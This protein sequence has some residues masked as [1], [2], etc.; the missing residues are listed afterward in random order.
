[1]SDVDIV[2]GVRGEISQSN[3]IT[4]RLDEIADRGDRATGATKRLEQ[5]FRGLNNAGSVLR[6]TLAAVGVGLA[7]KETITASMRLEQLNN[8]MLAAT[9]SSMDA[10]RSMAFVRQESERLGLVLTDTADG[11]SGFAASALRAGL[12]FGQTKQIFSDVATA[13][14]SLQLPGERVQLVF[15]AL[16]QMAAK[17]TV[18]MEELK[19]QLGE[20]LPGAFEIA[21]KSMGKTNA[22]FMEMVSNGEVLASEFLPKFAATLKDELG[23]SAVQAADSLQAATNRL[24]NAFFDLGTEFAKSGVADTY[25]ASINGVATVIKDP[26][27]L[28]A[29]RDVGA[30]MHDIAVQ[31]VEDIKLLDKFFSISKS[32]ELANLNDRI[33]KI[34]DDPDGYFNTGYERMVNDAELKSLEKKRDRIIEVQKAEE[35]LRNNQKNFEA[36]MEKVRE[37]NDKKRDEAAKKGEA[38]HVKTKS[39]LSTEKKLHNEITSAIKGSM[40][41]QEKL[42]A[43]IS[44]L[45]RLKGFAKTREEV[46]AL[47]KGIQN[48]QKEL[49]ELKLK[50]ELDS[51]LAKAFKSLADEIDDG[52]KDAFKSAFTESDGGFKKLIQGWKAT[53]KSFLADIAY[54]ALARP[55]VVSVLGMGGSAAGLSNGAVSSI[56]GGNGSSILGSLFSGSGGGG[57]SLSSIGSGISNINTLLNGGSSFINGIGSSLGFYNAVPSAAGV[58]G[59]VAPGAFGTTTLSGALAGGGLGIAAAQLL[60]LGNKNPYIATGAGIAGGAAAAGIAAALGAPL[61]PLGIGI[62]AFAGTALSGLFGGGTP[63]QTL[64]IGLTQNAAG[65]LSLNAV[66]NKNGSNEDATKFGNQIVEALNAL[67]AAVGGKFIASPSIE[68]NVGKKDPGTFIGGKRVSGT[69]G[70]LNA[71][72]RGYINNPSLFTGGNAQLT[73]ILKKS[74]GMGST[75]DQALQ[76][77]TLAKQIFGVTTDTTDQLATAM[78]ELNKQFDTMKTRASALGLPMDKVNQL[79]DDQKKALEGSIKALQAGFS[80]LEEMTQTFKAFLDAQALGSSSSLSPMEKLALVQSN[81]DSLLTKAQGGDASVTKDL[82]AAAATVLDVGRSIFASSKSFADL[83]AVIRTDIKEIAHQVGVPGYAVGTDYARSG[84]A[85]VG[86]QGPELVNFRGGESVYTASQ[87]ASMVGASSKQLQQMIALLQMLV[88]VNQDQAAGIQKVANTQRQA[89]SLAKVTK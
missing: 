80:S 35:I 26:E 24:Q 3:A 84:L 82:L 87:S 18:Q 16:E 1:M 75:A 54:Q 5:Q 48:T 89:N 31:M 60:G 13:A 64:G 52:F 72:I 20:S 62:G 33:A 46:D 7:F 88:E 58:M 6:D 56:L 22:Q 39:Q 10:Q 65:Q 37:Y 30:G 85:W 29:I 79:Y 61:G 11:F 47:T 14:A 32:G 8:R 81:Y 15:K 19:G 12:N 27:F 42:T 78:E 25:K 28:K 4:R 68:T 34:K 49:D 45:E 63:R 51:P 23:G 43:E 73:D 50:A 44:N 57:F 70:D 2:V 67:G 36:D 53:F 38:N 77:V 74:L 21:A 40:T 69:P 41:E 76:D 17:G 86:E 83:E 71:V 9:K 55:I 59:P 66:S